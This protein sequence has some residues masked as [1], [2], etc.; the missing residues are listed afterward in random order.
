HG[1]AS[2]TSNT[3]GEGLEIILAAANASEAGSQPVAQPVP[4]SSQ[5]FSRSQQSAYHPFHTPGQ[6][7]TPPESSAVPN[8]MTPACRPGNEAYSPSLRATQSQEYLQSINA[9]NHDSDITVSDLSEGTPLETGTEPST[10][11]RYSPSVEH[12]PKP[13]KRSSAGSRTKASALHQ[14]TL[15][16]YA[17]I[18]KTNGHHKK[19]KNNSHKSKNAS[20]KRRR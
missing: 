12:T 3:D 15:L 17:Q 4:S 11:L 10:I 6:P 13:K 18:R 19:S 5:Q 14:P 8:F 1:Y 7:L 2:Q 16:E 20:P 9:V